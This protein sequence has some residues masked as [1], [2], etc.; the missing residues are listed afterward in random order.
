MTAFCR[1]GDD[2]SEE[3]ISANLSF[4][5]AGVSSILV[6]LLKHHCQSPHLVELACEAICNVSLES[7]N[8]ERLGAEGACELLG[9]LLVRYCTDPASAQPICRAIG[10]LSFKLPGNIDRFKA[11]EDRVVPPLVRATAM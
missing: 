11:I 2:K 8:R 4:G 7:A 10:Y 1:Y 9:K 5:E 3:S 6:T